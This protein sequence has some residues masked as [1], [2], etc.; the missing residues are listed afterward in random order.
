[1]WAAAVGW[2]YLCV[3]WVCGRLFFRNTSKTPIIP[4]TNTTIPDRD[5]PGASFIERDVSEL[6]LVPALFVAVKLLNVSQLQMI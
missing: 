6:S 5:M 4:R 3:Y 2:W 1:M